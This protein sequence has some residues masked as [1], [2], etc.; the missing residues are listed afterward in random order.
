MLLV[1][2][3]RDDLLAAISHRPEKALFD[4]SLELSLLSNR[5]LCQLE[6]KCLLVFLGRRYILEHLHNALLLLGI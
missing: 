1:E 3:L 5:D 2:F 4:V 6:R